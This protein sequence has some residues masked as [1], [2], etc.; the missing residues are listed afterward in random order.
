MDEER[1]L[2]KS[3]TTGIASPSPVRKKRR[4]SVSDASGAL[5]GSTIVPSEAEREKRVGGSPLSNV[6]GTA[7]EDRMQEDGEDEVS[8]ALSPGAK[9]EA[10]G[11]HAYRSLIIIKRLK[12]LQQ[13]LEDC[14]IPLLHQLPPSS[15]PVVDLRN[16]D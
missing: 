10:D 3:W 12:K 9:D 8:P 14:F 2:L 4:V 16:H 1:Q 7:R 13:S 11:A 6:R 5:E 15:S